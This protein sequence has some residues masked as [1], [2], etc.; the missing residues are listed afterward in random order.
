MIM[1]HN[2]NN[3]NNFV[4]AK[5]WSTELEGKRRIDIRMFDGVIQMLFSLNKW[6]PATI[7][8]HL[9]MPF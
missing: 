5:A 2:N 7:P 8:M 4:L 3:H 6:Q 1:S 9:C